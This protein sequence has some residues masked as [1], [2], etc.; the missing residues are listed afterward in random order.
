MNI[1]TYQTTPNK[2][3][4]GTFLFT[5]CGHQFYSICT[6]MAYHGYLCPGC[7]SKGVLTTLYIRGSKEANEYWGRKIKDEIYP[8]ILNKGRMCEYNNHMSRERR[9]RYLN[10]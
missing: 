5:D 10:G 4:N 9:L 2:N 7:L 3:G 1:A 8:K 6:P